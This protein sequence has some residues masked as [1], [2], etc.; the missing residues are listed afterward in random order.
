MYYTIIDGF[1]RV[2]RVKYLG[3][4]DFWLCDRCFKI[5]LKDILY[6]DY[7]TPFRWIYRKSYEKDEKETHNLS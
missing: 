3:V 6:A 7:Q 1:F 4:N 2:E 5:N